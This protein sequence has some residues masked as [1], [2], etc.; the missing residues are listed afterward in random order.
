MM[1]RSGPGRLVGSVLVALLINGLGLVVIVEI[2]KHFV[3][4]K[5]ARGA[6]AEALHFQQ[7]AKKKKRRRIKQ[8]QVRVKHRQQAMPLP[9]LPSAMSAAGL[10]LAFAGETDL[11]G[12]LLGKGARFDGDLILREDAVDVPPRVI[13][14]ATAEYPRRAEDREIEG[15]VVFKLKVSKEGQVERAWVL[16]SE[17][18]GVFDTVAEKAVLQ[19]R[20]SPARYQGRAVAVL[21]KQKLV[22]RLGS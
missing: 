17:P 4:Q 20:F 18:P 22:F 11:F 8:H 16:E 2:N 15:H 19:Y 21:A 9:N 12:D 13:A 14:R 3:P 5:N 6:R 10:G 1:S 7:Q